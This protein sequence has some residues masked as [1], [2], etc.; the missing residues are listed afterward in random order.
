MALQRQQAGD[1]EALTGLAN[2]KIVAFGSHSRNSVCVPQKKRQRFGVID[3]LT[4]KSANVAVTQS[5]P[6]DCD[7]LFGKPLPDQPLIRSACQAI[8]AAEKAAEK[9]AEQGAK[10]KKECNQAHA[11]NAEGA[12]NVSTTKTPDIWIGLRSPLLPHP[13][14]KKGVDLAMLLHLRGL[15]AYAFDRVAALDL[16]GFGVRELASPTAGCGS[17]PGH[18]D[19]GRKD[20]VRFKLM[21]F[22]ADPLGADKINV[23]ETVRSDL[24]SS[25]EGLAVLA[26]KILVLIDGSKATKEQPDRCATPAGFVVLP[27]PASAM[28]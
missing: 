28:P 3:R 5:G 12:V 15:E 17:L 14:G 18:L 23:P 19:V 8:A 7:S 10:A 2:G 20:D 24:P 22:R 1:I 9:A 21:R 25:S 6:I 13:A 26:D 4:G 11:Y 16:G 27:R